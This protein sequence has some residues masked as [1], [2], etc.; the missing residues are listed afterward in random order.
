MPGLYV[1]PDTSQSE[2]LC[3]GGIAMLYPEIA[4]TMTHVGLLDRVS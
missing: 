2:S 1:I 3:I 4:G